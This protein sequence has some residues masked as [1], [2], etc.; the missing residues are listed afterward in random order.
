MSSTNSFEPNPATP[1]RRGVLALLAVLAFVFALASCGVEGSDAAGGSGGDDTTSTTADEGDG[2]DETTSTTEDDGGDGDDDTT[3]TT[4]DDGG[5]DGGDEGGGGD[6][7]TSTTF[8]FDDSDGAIRDALIKGFES[9][10]MTTAQATCLAD[11]YLDLGITSP[12]A[13][14]NLDIMAM[15]DLFSQCGISMED[16]GGIGA[17][18]GAELGA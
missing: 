2:G 11:G 17:G 13:G 4:E 12:D 6:D 15:M 10:G 16:L 9:A 14:E 3:T 8:G 1:R 7:T 18:L 5:T